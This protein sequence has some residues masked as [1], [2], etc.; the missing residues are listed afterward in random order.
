M[1]QVVFADNLFVRIGSTVYTLAGA[2]TIVVVDGSPGATSRDTTAAMDVALS[3]Q[4]SVAHV[5]NLTH[6]ES[7][8]VD[9]L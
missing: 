3:A 5:D 8:V 7:L 1:W 6:L 2:A 9:V 4:W